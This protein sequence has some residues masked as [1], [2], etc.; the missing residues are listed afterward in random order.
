M[1][2]AIR[3]EQTIIKKVECSP[4]HNGIKHTNIKINDLQTEIAKT[5]TSLQQKLDEPTFTILQNTIF[6]NKEK[7]FLQYKNTQT[8]KLKHLIF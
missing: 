1:E 7:T 4:I 3:F 2:R 5:K 8:K 6:N